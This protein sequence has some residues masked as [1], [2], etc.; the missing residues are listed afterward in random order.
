MKYE[1]CNQAFSSSG[2]VPA[3]IDLFIGSTPYEKLKACLPIRRSNFSYESLQFGQFAMPLFTGFLKGYDCLDDLDQLQ[4]D[5]AIKHKLKEMPSSR[6]MGEFLRDFSNDNRAST[7]DLLTDQSLEARAILTPDVPVVIDIDS[8]AHVQRGKKIEGLAYNYKNEW[9]LD[10]LVAFDELGFCYGMELRPG[11]TFSSVGA[12]EMIKRIFNQIKNPKKKKHFRGDSAFCNEEVIR[13]CMNK[14]VIFTIT[15]HGNILWEEAVARG[16]VKEWKPWEYSDKEKDA[17]EKAKINLPIVELGSYQYQPGWAPNIKF[18]VVVK[19]TW[20][21]K[22]NASTPEQG[23]KYYALLTNW[24][25]FYNTVQTVM[26]FHQKRGNA[27]NFIREGKY[28]YEPSLL[29]T[30]QRTHITQKKFEENMLLFQVGSLVLPVLL[31]L[32]LQ[33]IIKR[34]WI[35]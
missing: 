8:T 21:E 3:L 26:A 10:S 7:N 33:T 35:D 31:L 24:N 4:I 34:R 12:S 23:W 27:E 1:G 6:T 32:K 22:L 25:L 11:N 2:G 18:H 29:L 30:I 9:C 20:V 5:P 19:K 17:A 15:A 16:E 13:A 14:K 28:G